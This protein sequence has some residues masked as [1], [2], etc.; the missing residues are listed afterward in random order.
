MHLE[1]QS[2]AVPSHHPAPTCVQHRAAAR[3][4]KQDHHSARAVVGVLSIEQA[5]CREEVIS[6]QNTPCHCREAMQEHRSNRGGTGAALIACLLYAAA[7]L[8][9]RVQ[10][11]PEK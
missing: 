2:I 5:V 9:R 7:P 6:K 10:H 3:R 4:L 11:P 8:P 1:R